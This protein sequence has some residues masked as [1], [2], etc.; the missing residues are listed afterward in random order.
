MSKKEVNTILCKL[1][2]HIMKQ[3]VLYRAFSRVCIIIILFTIYTI[4]VHA[5]QEPIKAFIQ[6]S[7]NNYIDYIFKTYASIEYIDTTEYRNIING[8][9]VTHYRMKSLYKIDLIGK[10]IHS[11]ILEFHL[12]DGKNEKNHY[13]GKEDNKPLKSIYLFT[14]YINKNWD[15]PSINREESSVSFKGTQ[16]FMPFSVTLYYDENN[17]FPRQILVVSDNRKIT[18]SMKYSRH[19]GIYLL[20]RV[21]LDFAMDFVIVKNQIT[22]RVVRE[23]YVLQPGK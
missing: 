18:V 17:Y 15:Q 1:T 19:S 4:P 11:R 13:V 9:C 8:T 3:A 2:A 7:Y 22:T 20:D 12:F 21:E 16:W 6:Q 5:N 23:Y 14:D 10:R